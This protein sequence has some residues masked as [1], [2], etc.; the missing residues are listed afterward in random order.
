VARWQSYAPEQSGPGLGQSE[1]AILARHDADLGVIA[2]DPRWQILPVF[3]GQR[4]WTDDYANI[5][6]LIRW[7][8]PLN[9]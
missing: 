3:P 9:P 4:I 2:S 5:L 7:R 1:W 6:A 8:A